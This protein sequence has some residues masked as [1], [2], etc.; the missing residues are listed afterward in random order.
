[1]PQLILRHSLSGP[2]AWQ[3]KLI[4]ILAPQLRKGV[5]FFRHLREE[6]AQA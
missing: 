6:W 2:E 5:D 1:V 4:S 3:A